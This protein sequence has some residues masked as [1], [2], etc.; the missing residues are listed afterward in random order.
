[1]LNNT[2]VPPN[3][4]GGSQGVTHH[5]NVAINRYESARLTFFNLLKK[6]LPIPL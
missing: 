1:M 4:C 6:V 2:F 3:D 5:Y